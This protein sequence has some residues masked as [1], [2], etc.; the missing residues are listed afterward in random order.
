MAHLK[1]NHPYHAHT[2]AMCV[3]PFGLC[4]L[5]I[6]DVFIHTQGKMALLESALNRVRHFAMTNYFGFQEVSTAHD[7]YP[8]LNSPCFLI[9][10]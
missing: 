5:G 2:F 6:E 4:A 1:S 10:S 7:L 8:D 9:L 3:I